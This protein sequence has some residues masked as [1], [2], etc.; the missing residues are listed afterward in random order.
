LGWRNYAHG[1]AL[2]F[3]SALSRREGGYAMWIDAAGFQKSLAALPL[4]IYQAAH[5]QLVA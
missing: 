3:L 1:Y 2:R 5:R 4:T